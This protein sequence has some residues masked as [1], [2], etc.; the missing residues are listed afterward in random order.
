M[1]VRFRQSEHCL[2]LSLVAAPSRRGGSP[3]QEHVASLGSIP[4]PPTVAD[5]IRFWQ[6]LYERL[7]KLSN[8]LDAETHRRVLG[9]AHERVP[10]VTPDERRSAGKPANKRESGASRMRL[11]LPWRG[12][13]S[14][15]MVPPWCKTMP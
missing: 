3:R 4:Q 10:M 11:G 14:L 8:R 15:S 6:K 1:F 9:A 2:G 13:G 7:A 12:T 5:R